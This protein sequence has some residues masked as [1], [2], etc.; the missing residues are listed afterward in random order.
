MHVGYTVRYAVNTLI[1]NIHREDSTSF[2]EPPCVNEEYSIH[3]IQDSFEK[4]VI[5]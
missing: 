1:T 4:S 5:D 2:L 3:G